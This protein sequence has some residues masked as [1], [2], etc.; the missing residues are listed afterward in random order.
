MKS[1]QIALMAVVLVVPL[2]EGRAAEPRELAA[3][4]KTK[5]RNI[6]LEIGRAHV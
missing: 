1:L 2:G 4:V 6:L 5:T 3:P